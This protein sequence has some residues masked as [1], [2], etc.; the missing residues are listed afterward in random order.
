MDEHLF[1]QIVEEKGLELD[2]WGN[3][4]RF[5]RSSEGESYLIVSFGRDG[6]LDVDDEVDYFSVVGGSDIR[7][8]ADHDIVV[9]DGRSL[10]LVGK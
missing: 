9:I 8:D 4:L 5:V 6:R 1:E 2:A 7:G 10:F 3:K